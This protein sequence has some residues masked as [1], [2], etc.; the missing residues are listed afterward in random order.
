MASSTSIRRLQFCN[1]KLESLL[2]ITTAINDNLPVEQLLLKFEQLLLEELKLGKVVVFAYSTRWKIVLQSGTELSDAQNIDVTS[3]LLPYKEITTGTST[4]NLRLKNYDFIIPVYHSDKPIAFVLIGD[5]EEEQDGVSP[6]I[7]HLHFVQT[8]TNIIFVAVENKRLFIENLKQE[9]L[10]REM[11][12]ASKVQNMLIPD[13]RTFPKNPNI[14]V[15]AYYLPHY[16]VGGDY[17][18][19]EALS[20]NEFFFC[21]AD[22]SGKGISAA[23]LMS[24]FQATLQAYLTE[25]MHLE[26]LIRQLNR[27]VIRNAQGDRFITFFAGIY[28]YL[29]REFRYINAGHNPPYLYDTHTSEFET[30][31]TGCVGVGMLDEIPSIQTGRKYLANRSKLIM[32]T[33]G[34]AELQTQ[35][36]DEIAL[37][38]IQSCLSDSKNITETFSKIKSLLALNKENPLVFDDITLLGLEFF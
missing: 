18:D 9:G 30:L 24:N 26:A 28:N 35:N 36:G 32:F 12:L 21:I 6:T 15:E 23:M 14:A 10:K 27:I 38:Q 11:E 37:E 4:E 7:K 2:A 31:K 13:S 29:S 3:D 1:F 17:Y 22:V 34:I 20:P 19:F 8:L 25:G 5:V 16:Q 33:D